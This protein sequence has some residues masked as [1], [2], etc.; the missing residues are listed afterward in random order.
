M[1]HL[2]YLSVFDQRP[3]LVLQDHGIDTVPAL[4]TAEGLD[5]VFAG[6][7]QVVVLLVREQARATSAGFCVELFA[8]G[9]G[10]NSFVSYCFS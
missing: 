5:A 1:S 3:D 10:P 8:R 9:K 7:I 6:V 2:T 4:H